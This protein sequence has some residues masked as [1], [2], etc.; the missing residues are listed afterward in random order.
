MKLFRQK[1]IPRDYVVRYPNI[2]VFSELWLISLK[3]HDF[4]PKFYLHP[5]GS[6]WVSYITKEVRGING[7]MIPHR[8]QPGVKVYMIHEQMLYANKIATTM[9]YTVSNVE[10]P[11]HFTVPKPLFHASNCGLIPRA[12]FFD[13]LNI[14]NNL[15]VV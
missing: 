11:N 12:R 4:A 7:I 14:K 8:D 13:R 6:V 15:V 1:I 2:E 10:V 5:D 9:P 3:Q